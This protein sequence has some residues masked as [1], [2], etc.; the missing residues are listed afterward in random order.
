MSAWTVL[1]IMAGAL[2]VSALISLLMGAFIRA[3][4]GS[5]DVDDELE[6][7]RTVQGNATHTHEPA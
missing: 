4:K 1:A 5:T 7:E 2:A 3:G 6:Y